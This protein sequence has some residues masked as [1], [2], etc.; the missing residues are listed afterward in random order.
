[1]HKLFTYGKLQKKPLG[2]NISKRVMMN[3]IEKSIK[4][5][6]ILVALIAQT[7]CGFCQKKGMSFSEAANNGFTLQHLDSIYLSGLHVDSLKAAFSSNLYDT[8]HKSYTY[9]LK[10]LSRYLS[11][12]GFKWGKKTQCFNK[13]YFSST[14]EID[15]FLFNFPPGQ[16]EK[17]KETE[18]ESL[19]NE[20]I[21]TYKFPLSAKKSFS[22]CSS[23]MYDD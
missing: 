11:S 13:L 12:K 20:F 5:T 6:V 8:V 4:I 3:R 21:K 22:L 23:V 9:T 7:L 10:Q 19:L 17:G 16:I 14:G 2:N 1:M 18:F 15:Y